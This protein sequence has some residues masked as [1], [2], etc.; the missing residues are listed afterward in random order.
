MKIQP[1]LGEPFH[2]LKVI[3]FNITSQLMK[4]LKKTK[5]VRMKLVSLKK[6]NQ[7]SYD[8]KEKFPFTE[9]SNPDSLSHTSVNVIIQ[10]SSS[11]PTDKHDE[12]LGSKILKLTLRKPKWLSN[13]KMQINRF[14]NYLLVARVN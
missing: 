6:V 14:L 4:K 8:K 5:I 7:A 1:S 10:D 11:I 9:T 2:P 13:L 12:Q 3:G